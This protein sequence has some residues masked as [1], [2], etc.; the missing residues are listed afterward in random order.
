M[1]SKLTLLT[2]GLFAEL[3]VSAQQI[4]RAPDGKP[5]FQGIWQAQSRAAYGL[6]DH[7]AKNG[8]PGGRSVVDTGE[9]PYQPAALAKKV[10]NFKNRK[11]ADPLGKCFFPGVPRIMY[12]E[13]PFQIFQ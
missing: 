8:M 1:F 5:N 2:I 9:I 6:E 7:A 4:P 11:T 12:M 13:L 10:E 3:S